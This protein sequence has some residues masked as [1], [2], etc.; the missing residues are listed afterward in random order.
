[1]SACP[2]HSV[3]RPSRAALLSTL[4]LLPP[5]FACD[6]DSAAAPGRIDG[7][8]IGVDTLRLAVGEQADVPV[9]VQ[10]VGG[11]LPSVSVAWSTSDTTV[12]RV[13]GAGR[14]LGMGVGETVLTAEA[15]GHRDQAI[16]LV[17]HAA[18]AT[19]AIAQDSVRLNEGLA[20][21]L[22]V[23]ATDALGR[24]VPATSVRW[25]SGDVQVAVVDSIGGVLALRAGETWIVGEGTLASD[26]V[27]LRVEPGYAAVAPGATHVCAARASGSPFCWGARLESGVAGR[28]S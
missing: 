25:V 7:V 14:V 9:N 22:S 17:V 4:C 8:R 15:G 20:V 23:H 21:T 11:G 28:G 5:L 1:M 2:D 27:R 26:S 24:A 19:V 16:V 13:D 18:A 12:A 3:R 10:F 6:G